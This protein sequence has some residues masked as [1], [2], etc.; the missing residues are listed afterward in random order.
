MLVIN[1]VDAQTNS[2][3]TGVIHNWSGRN[4]LGYPTLTALF[5]ANM[6]PD[7]PLAYLNFGGFGAAENLVSVTRVSDPNV[8]REFV[9]PNEAPLWADQPYMMIDERFRRIQA[10]HQQT[11]DALVKEGTTVGGNYRN[12]QAYLDA[13]TKTDSIKRFA[14]FIPGSDQLEAPREL[15][16]NYYSTLHQQI[17]ISLLAFKAEVAVAADV[18][19]GGFDTHENHD[20]DHPVL[21]SNV[22]DGLDYLWTQA[23]V[24]GL[25]DRLVVLIGTDFGRTPHF[26]ANEGKDHWP[27]SSTIV[28][29]KNAAWANRTFGQTDEGH[30]AYNINPVNGQ[31]DDN[32]GVIIRPA[33]VHKA[34]RNYLGIDDSPITQRFAFNNVE[35]FNF[36]SV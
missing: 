19:E 23:E 2:H 18:I 16:Q 4:S 27:I 21:L 22:A 14:D 8:L 31:R 29:E 5:A 7:F 20:S 11:A 33:H 28:M 1:G 15:E 32:Q 17:Q 3:T 24:L 12:R 13:L 10:M 35:D 34:L 30:N 6:A 36:F 25:A 26:N 9:A